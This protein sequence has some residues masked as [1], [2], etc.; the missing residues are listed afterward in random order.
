MSEKE[1]GEEFNLPEITSPPWQ[2]G[3]R[4]MFALL[5][6]VLIA[7]LAIR[8]RQII[9]PL[10]LALLLAYLLH[11]LVLRVE[12]W[13]RLPRSVAVL[14]VYGMVVLL[15][16]GATTGA[17]FAITQQI[18]GLVQDLTRLAVQLPQQLRELS[19]STIMFGPWTVDLSTVN[20]EPIVNSLISTVQPLLSR[21]GTILASALGATAST[22]GMLI[23]IMVMGYYLLRDF[24]QLDEAF[25]D[26]VPHEY[27]A[28]FSRLLRETGAVWHAFL[29]GQ[30]ILGVAMGV[31]TAVVYGA[32]GLRFALGLGLIAGVL[33]FVPIFGPIIAGILAVLVALFQAGN[34]FGL[35]PLAY[36]LII[37]AVATLIQ[38]FENTILVPRIIGHS[39][40]LHPLIVLVAAVSGG[41]L[42]GVLGVL[43]AAPVV[44]TLRLWGGY[45]YRKSVGLD[46][47]PSLVVERE[48]EEP[49]S[50]W[51]RLRAR[52]PLSRQR[53]PAPE[54]PEAASVGSVGDRSSEGDS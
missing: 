42:A 15:L 34:W 53:R 52:L 18:I 5:L 39:L 28:D 40:N 14:V 4:L 12:R 13:L 38:Q 17:G 27:R 41:F 48:E 9:G 21:T 31:L 43:L 19:E 2:T 20:L 46:S 16:A 6:V 30:A 22:L 36:A 8:L 35:S 7:A 24:G 29:R 44:A 11:P 51:D 26:L 33:E 10:V 25:L 1:N 50:F 49:I 32:L 3:T 23:L 47:W 45:F 37:A 54:P